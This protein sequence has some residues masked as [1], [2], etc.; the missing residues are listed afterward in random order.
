MKPKSLFY[1]IYFGALIG[2]GA[3]L[4][5]ALII[6][7]CWLSTFEKA[8][9]LT[10]ANQIVENYLD[11]G[12]L[13]AFGEEYNSSVSKYETKEAIN[14]RFNEIKNGSDL[15]ITSSPKKDNEHPVAYSV[16]VNDQ[17]IMTL[18]FKQSDK[19][20]FFG[21]KPYYLGKYQLEE[22]LF[23]T[24]DIS[25]PEGATL[26][27]NGK[28]IE[29]EDIKTLAVSEELDGKKI[30]NKQT[31]TV[32]PL[33]STDVN[34]TATFNGN[35]LEVIQ[36]G[37]SYTVKQDID[38]TTFDKVNAFSLEGS[39]AYAKYMQNHSNIQTVTQYLDTSTLFYKKLKSIDVS[40]GWE[41]ASYSFEGEKVTETHKFT[42]DIYCCRVKFTQVL[43]YKTREYRDNFDKYVYIKKSGNSYK[44]IDMQSIGE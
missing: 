14:N 6:L 35:A 7:F 44:I 24:V 11:K 40:Y 15:V 8:Q 9:P 28:Q 23:A 18:F 17:T 2:L 29:V 16:K 43:R 37:N 30:I 39:K 1:K 41:M 10:Q 36:N 31:V 21:V 20:R 3:I 32:G 42:D 25:F 38:N 22:S 5:T 27:I 26:S 33:L 12:D 4:G 13:F 19:A 34:I